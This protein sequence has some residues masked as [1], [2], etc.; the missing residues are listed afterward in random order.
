MKIIYC[1]EI[2]TIEIVTMSKNNLLANYNNKK[3]FKVPISS[4]L[5]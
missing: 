4:R 3:I 5:I 1:K 2:V